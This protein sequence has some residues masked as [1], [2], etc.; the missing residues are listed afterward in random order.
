MLEKATS[1]LS[2]FLFAIGTSG[3]LQ[4]DFGAPDADGSLSYCLI[5]TAILFSR[6][7]VQQKPVSAAPFLPAHL[8]I[9][10]Q[11]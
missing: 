3:F 1:F 10:L 4:R 2:F 11:L 9:P 7:A 5:V 6:P 8:S